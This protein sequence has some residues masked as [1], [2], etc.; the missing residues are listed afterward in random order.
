MQRITRR[1]KILELIKEKNIQTQTELM[2]YLKIAGFNATQATI[3]RDIKQLGLIKVAVKDGSYKYIRS[4][5]N[6]E[7]D[8]K[9][10]TM[11]REAVISI[12]KASDL[13]VLKTISGSANSACFTIDKLNING[14]AGTLAG[15]DT[16]FVAIQS[17]DMQDKVFTELNNLL[18]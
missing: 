15:D 12:Q 4:H 17:K 5:Q 2:K 16:I 9:L 11:F 10:L 13:I 7:Y 1:E 6:K 8:N 18:D 14:V 3:S